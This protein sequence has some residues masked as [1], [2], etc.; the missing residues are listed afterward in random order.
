MNDAQ[1]IEKLYDLRL[2]AM[3]EAFR[4]ELG[5]SGDPQLSFAERFG[6]VVEQQ[7]SAREEGRLARRLK[8][9]QLKISASIE[10]VDL[11]TP[12]GLDRAAFLELAELGFL[13]GAGNVIVTGATGLG[14]TYLAC[15]LADRAL[16]RGHTALYKRLPKLVFEL[17]LARA[18]GS[19][20]RLLEKLA[21]VE[22]LVLDDWGLAVLEGQA[23]N[24]VMDLVDDR[25][26]IR[27]TIVAS[28]LPVSEWHHLIG[29]PSIADG[30]LDRLRH[31]AERIELKG[32]SLR[33]STPKHAPQ[34]T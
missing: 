23:A 6:L 14:K 32:E 34:L 3:A 24:D 31:R 26:G 33:Q 5:R 1:T 21:R 30:L 18:D 28:Q 10:E 2:G 17:A 29:D 13:R 12:R 8:A 11:R 19:Y 7:W 4:A 9:A 20:L 25:A 16:R 27:S 22:L 15:A